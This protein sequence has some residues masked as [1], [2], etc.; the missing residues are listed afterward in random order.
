MMPAPRPPSRAATRKASHSATRPP[1]RATTSHAPGAA[2]PSTESGV[3]IRTGSGFQE[4]GP[5]TV[6]RPRWAICRP[7]TIHPHGSVVGTDGINS[8]ASARAML[9]ATTR[10]SSR[11]DDVSRTY[12][13]PMSRRLAPGA[14]RSAP[15][16]TPSCRGSEDVRA[17]PR[18]AR[19]L[20]SSDR[21]IVPNVRGRRW[22][23]LTSNCPSVRGQLASPPMGVGCSRPVRGRLSRSQGAPV[24]RNRII[25]CLAAAAA[26]P[27]AAVVLAGCGGDSATASS[28]T[29][30]GSTATI[31]LANNGNVGNVLVDSKGKTVYL[32]R[33]D[34]ST[35]STCTGACATAWPPVRAT[36]KPTV[37][38]G[39]SADKVGT[40][41]RSDGDPQVT[42]AGHPLYRY[43]GDSKPGDAAG[44]GISAFG[45]TWYVLSSSGAAVTTSGGSGGANGY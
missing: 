26:I 7:Q 42:Y 5:A 10:Q 30:T 6:F 43:Q 36:G 38:S 41:P 9:A 32:F 3:V 34:T 4:G 15:T 33:K 28:K 18:H 37:A 11:V 14:T 8:D 21:P 27:T 44:Q 40:T 35:K 25:K 17:S 20:D 22:R 23:C 19:R 2:A 31:G 39:L 1:A 12:Q 45:A 29:V 16:R 24:T 13:R